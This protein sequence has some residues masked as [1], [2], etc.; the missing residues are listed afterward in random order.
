MGKTNTRSRVR[1]I[2][3]SNEKAISD[4]NILLTL[5]WQGEGLEKISDIGN[6]TKVNSIIRAW[7][8]I[9]KNEIT[10]K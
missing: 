8:Y 4:V 3:H 1:E 10:T 9:R 6:G 5:F 2:L 7:N